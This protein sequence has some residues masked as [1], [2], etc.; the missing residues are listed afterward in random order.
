MQQIKTWGEAFDYT[1]RVK[2]KRTPSAKTNA[3]NAGHV[4]EYA[5]RSLP[6]KRMSVAGWWMEMRATLEDE[7]RPGSTINRIISAG[8]TVMKFTHLAGLHTQV[9]PQ[10]ERAKEGEHR[11]TYFT[12]EQVDQLAQIAVDIYDRQDLADAILF[13]AFTGVRQGELLK[14]RSDDVDVARSQIWVGG[15]PTLVTKGK[16]VRNVTLHPKIEQIVMNRLHQDYLFR[17][18]W[19]NKDQLYA[20]FKKVRKQAGIAEDHVWHTLRHSFGTWLGETTHPRQIMAL[21]GHANIETS[22]RYVKATDE[23]TRSAVLAI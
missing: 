12:K 9:C 1:W 18:D 21:M 11:L 5:G 15:K 20:A 22:L 6:L 14:L 19:N 2:W 7:G 10:F 23:A 3:I 17:D 13:S 16:N 4:T 8:T